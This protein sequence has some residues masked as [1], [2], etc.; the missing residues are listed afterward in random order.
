MTTVMLADDEPLLRY[1]LQKSL[2]E[3]WPEAEVIAQA[4]NGDEAIALISELNPDVAFLDIHMPG[5]TGLEVALA[6][7][8]LAQPPAIVFLTAYDEYAIKAFDQGAIDY[9]LKPLD[10]T[11]LQK[12]VLRLQ[13][14]LA[15]NRALAAPSETDL[16]YFL[17]LVQQNT[18]A[19]LR[20]LN[21]QQGDSIRVIAIE[22]IDFFKA[23][24]KYISVF[25]NHEEFLIRLSTKQLEDQL[26]L[27]QFIRIHRS[28]LVNLNKVERIEKSFTG[29]MQLWVKGY[30]QPLAVARAKQ[31]LFK[32]S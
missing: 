16:A 28:T 10:E 9:L 32:P 12:T 31:H 21:V 22:D 30:N 1:H 24:D 15:D 2:A 17:K 5:L 6:C 7:N 19:P 8:K 3:V 11:R 25:S 14:V 23:E 26:P 18:S 27:Q 20:W 13:S 4:A 29:N